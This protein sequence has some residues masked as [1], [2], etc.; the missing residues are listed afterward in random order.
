LAD[1]VDGPGQHALRVLDERGK[2][3][4]EDAG[5]LAIFVAALDVRPPRFWSSIVSWPSRCAIH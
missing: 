2:L 5:K 3:S 1:F 4:G